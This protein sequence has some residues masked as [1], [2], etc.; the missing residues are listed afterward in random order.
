MSL[1][2]RNQ[3][4]NKKMKIKEIIVV[5]GRDDTIAIQQAVEADTIETGGSSLDQE[6]IERI[7]LAQERRGVIIFTD[8]DYPGERLRKLIAQ[9]VP[10]CKHAFLPREKAVSPQGKYGVE[11]ASAEHIREALQQ[12]RWE[13]PATGETEITWS[14]LLDLGLIGK[15]AS[16][17]LRERLGNRLGIGYCNGKQLYKRLQAFRISREE[18][19]S[20]YQAALEEVHRESRDRHT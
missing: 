5:E 8:P 17:K 12:F 7:R 13:A 4:Q 14:Q 16:Q 18:L 15:D 6:K 11:H 1:A 9:Q 2:S 19:E 3:K 10:G 20:A